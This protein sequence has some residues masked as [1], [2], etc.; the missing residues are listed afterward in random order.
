MFTFN[1]AW[2][3]RACC[4]VLLFAVF[5]QDGPPAEPPAPAPEPP[6][7]KESPAPERPMTPDERLR[8]EIASL[9]A[10]LHHLRAELAKAQL[11]AS[12]AQRELAELRQFMADHD[13][14]GRDFEQYRAVRESVE[15]EQRRREMEAARERRE[16]E[17]AA[18]AAR[19]QA[20]RAQR[21]RER[22]EAREVQRYRNAG[23]TALGLDVWMGPSSYHYSTREATPTPLRFD[24]IFGFFYQDA[25]QQVTIDY[26]SM[27]IS[28]SVLNGSNAVRNIGI[29]VTF[30]DSRGN[31]VG[32]E[33]IQI[34]NARPDVPYPFTSTVRMAL[35]RAF[36]SSSAYVLYADPISP[37]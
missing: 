28:G 10:E 34:D 14:Y 37:N 21:D 24:P 13:T 3:V 33:I 23:F 25:G 30:F 6:V 35:D 11:E 29:A 8:A 20:A 31:Q 4:A 7:A 26:T 2:I 18:R 16:A 19:Q 17:A 12:Q 15:R 22:S 36:S 1:A 9:L 32:H 5:A 27:T